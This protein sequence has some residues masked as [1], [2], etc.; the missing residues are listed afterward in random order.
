MFDGAPDPDLAE[1]IEMS[2]APDVTIALRRPGRPVAR[3]GEVLP[4]GRS[5]R[6][7]TPGR[8]RGSPRRAA[9]L[10]LNAAAEQLTAEL[11][12]T[13]RALELELERRAGLERAL[14]DERAL[15]G[16]LRAQ[17]AQHQ[18]R[19]EQ[20]GA[21]IADYE[22]RLAGYE[23]RLAQSE[24]LRADS[25]APRADSGALR[26]DSG[27]LRA[28]PAAGTAGALQ[29]PAR[30]DQL[31]AGADGRVADATVEYDVLGDLHGDGAGAPAGGGQPAGAREPTA[32]APEPAT[33]RGPQG[34]ESSPPRR[35]HDH[36]PVA[37]SRRPLNPSLRHRTWWFGRL[38]AL[39]LLTA[40]LAAIWI[41]VRSTI[42]HP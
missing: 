7:T 26:A 22:A 14:E 31:A 5:T 41:V 34:H 6:S 8:R 37:R 42:I 19:L 28:E 11:A 2:V 4:A 38:V 23:E 9:D 13:R 39:V 36:P 24:A 12:A 17:L 21:L 1:Q 3:P 40:V 16:Q 32:A 35:S 33:A 20:S 10:A 18:A 27:A 25:G 29:Q 15:E 30:D